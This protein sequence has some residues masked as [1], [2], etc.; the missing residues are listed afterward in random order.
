MQ[1]DVEILCKD[2]ELKLNRTLNQKEEEIIKW[3]L[4]K[5]DEIQKEN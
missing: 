1:S 2:V 3:M 5:Q 4:F